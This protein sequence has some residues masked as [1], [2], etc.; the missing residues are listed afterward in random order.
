MP[1]RRRHNTRQHQQGQQPRASPE[2]PEVHGQRIQEEQRRD[3]GRHQRNSPDDTRTG[4]LPA[5]SPDEVQRRLRL[6]N[7]NVLELG[8][9]TMQGGDF[10]SPPHLIRITASQLTAR[11]EEDKVTTAAAEAPPAQRLEVWGAEG[12]GNI[13]CSFCLHAPHGVAWPPPYGRGSFS[14]GDENLELGGAGAHSG[15]GQA[16]ISPTWLS[17]SGDEDW[18]AWSPRVCEASVSEG[19][20]LRFEVVYLALSERPQEVR[21]HLGNVRLRI[22]TVVRATFETCWR[23]ESRRTILAHNAPWDP[24]R[25]L[26]PCEASNGTTDSA[27]LHACCVAGPLR[28]PQGS[29]EEV[30]R[31]FQGLYTTDLPPWTSHGFVLA[32]TLIGCRSRIISICLNGAAEEPIVRE[33]QLE[34][35]QAPSTPAEIKAAAAAA[36]VGEMS[37]RDA[38][39]PWLLVHTSSPVHVPILVLAKL[40]ESPLSEGTNARGD[41]VGPPLVAEIVGALC[42]RGP[43]N[44]FNEDVRDAK[45]WMTLHG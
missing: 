25:Q 18:A 7:A 16:P 44:A 24:R 37:L 30:K 36:S 32:N 42:L 41:A 21:P 19:P 3:H 22:A 29:L 33:V 34:K 45:M 26:E 20:L 6:C 31:S 14:M 15:G 43:Q 8:S 2:Q 35:P 13:G 27:A 10:D 38:R 9:A 28:D 11:S 12:S 5:G 1:S 17:I 23:I 4:F 40:K 39:G